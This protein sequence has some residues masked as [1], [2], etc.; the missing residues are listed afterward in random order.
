MMMPKNFEMG[1]KIPP[2][3]ET[4]M[5]YKKVKIANNAAI[6]RNPNII[7][8]GEYALVYFEFNKS[9]NIILS[10]ITKFIRLI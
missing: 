7:M 5:G 1:S 8:A 3:Y 9:N 2:T 10:L 4:V 6:L